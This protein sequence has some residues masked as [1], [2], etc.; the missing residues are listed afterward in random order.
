MKSPAIILDIRVRYFNPFLGEFAQAEGEH[1]EAD[2]LQP[3][4]GNC[5][6]DADRRFD[7]H[8]EPRLR[9]FEMS[10]HDRPQIVLG[11]PSSA[12]MGAIGMPPDLCDD[13][14]QDDP[15]DLVGVPG[16]T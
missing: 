8:S 10:S 11:L 5:E 2:F 12:S 13:R 15:P 7:Q 6:R 3:A 1:D 4:P 9:R 16:S 14:S